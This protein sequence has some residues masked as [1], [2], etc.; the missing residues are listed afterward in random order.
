MSKFWVMFGVAVAVSITGVA[1]SAR[2]VGMSDSLLGKAQAEF[3]VKARDALIQRRMTMAARAPDEP[4]SAPETPYVVASLGPVAAPTIVRPTAPVPAVTPAATT[5]AM[6]S[7]AV[8]AAAPSPPAA[9]ELPAPAAVE[10]IKM[11]EPPQAAPSEASITEN[12]VTTGS[13]PAAAPVAVASAPGPMTAVAAAPSTVAPRE[14]AKMTQKTRR[15]SNEPR[16]KSIARRYDGGASGYSTPYN[17]QALRAHAPEIAAAIA[18][19]M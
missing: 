15:A 7:P 6:D 1:W 16:T 9:P 8:Q 18:R 19:Y 10:E 5:V 14:P 3:A 2:P 12:L 17:L 11:T 13:A 4:V